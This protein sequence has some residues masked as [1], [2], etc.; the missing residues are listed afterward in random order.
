[1]PSKAIDGKTDLRQLTSATIKKLSIA[2]RNCMFCPCN[3][4]PFAVPK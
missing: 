1:M 4:E 2:L 3:E